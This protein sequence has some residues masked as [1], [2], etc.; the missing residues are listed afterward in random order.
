MKKICFY[1]LIF[2]FL[3]Y[4][5]CYSSRSV[6]KEILYTQDLGEPD[7]TVVITMNDEN[8]IELRK[9][10]YEV[11][12]DTLYVNGFKQ[13]IDHVEPI[14]VKIA[15]DDIQSVEIKERDD[16]ASCGMIIGVS[17]LAFFIIMTIAVAN[18]DHSPKKCRI[19]GL[20]DKG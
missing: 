8:V 13:Y 7:G 20:E 12:G 4:I 9:G 6:N 17:A 10:I 19:E 16:L 18:Q 1:I 11:V 15:L 14:D 3:N 2:S 5:G